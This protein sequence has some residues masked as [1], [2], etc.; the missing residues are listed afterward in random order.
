MN[1]AHDWTLV[2]LVALLVAIIGS[3]VWSLWRHRVVEDL[4]A[5]RE[6]LE[7]REQ[8]ERDILE[9]LQRVAPMRVS[10]SQL[11]EPDVEQS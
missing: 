7:R 2:G 4:H 8:W 3:A 10:E 1:A 5:V 11:E 6:L 9:R